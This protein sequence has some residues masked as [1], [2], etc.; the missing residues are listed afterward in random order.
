MEKQQI[1]PWDL[2]PRFSFRIGYGRPRVHS[3]L[4]VTRNTAPSLLQVSLLSA[5]GDKILTYSSRGFW[6]HLFTSFG[7]EKKNLSMDPLNTEP[8]RFLCPKAGN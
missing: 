5:T 4:E 6:M 7:V 2:V 3:I 8:L 1:V